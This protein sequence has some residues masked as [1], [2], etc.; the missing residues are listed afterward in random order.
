MRQCKRPGVGG[1]VRQKRAWT[2]ARQG[3]KRWAPV[4][5]VPCSHSSHDAQ[6][7]H[8][9]GGG[10]NSGGPTHARTC[11]S[12]TSSTLLG[13]AVL[14]P[15]CSSCRINLLQLPPAA[16]TCQKPRAVHVDQPRGASHAERPA[17]LTSALIP[18]RDGSHANNAAAHT[19]HQGRGVRGLLACW[20]AHNPPQGLV[21]AAGM[22]SCTC[23][24]TRPRRRHRR[25]LLPPFLR[26]GSSG[27]SCHESARLLPA[28][29]IATASPP[30]ASTMFPSATPELA[31]AVAPAAVVA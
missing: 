4:S 17:C 9:G 22:C 12:C 11:R 6:I 20:R 1:C 14:P 3:L 13:A 25:L 26:F 16:S 31:I 30:W 2:C 27:G 8:L 29:A 5:P 21:P 10:G 19:A 7:A 23:P 28:M 24:A 15:P 18:P